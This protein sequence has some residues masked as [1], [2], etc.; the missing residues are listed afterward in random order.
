MRDAVFVVVLLEASAAHAGLVGKIDALGSTAAEEPDADYP[1][2]R[3]AILRGL[4]LEAHGHPHG[5]CP[6]PGAGAAPDG[7]APG[8]G[9]PGAGVAGYPGRSAG[10]GGGGGECGDVLAP[11]QSA[12]FAYHQSAQFADRFGDQFGDQFGGRF[13]APPPEAFPQFADE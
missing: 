9:A 12:Q 4:H 7:E 2:L 8:V 3:D 6:L 13:G 1:H 11:R 10:A 5:A